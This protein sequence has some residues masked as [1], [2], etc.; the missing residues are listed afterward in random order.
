MKKFLPALLLAAM[1]AVASAQEA[2][3]S[4]TQSLERIRHSNAPVLDD[5]DEYKLHQE[6][7]KGRTIDGKFLALSAGL[8]AFTIADYEF[9]R[10]V[11]GN[12]CGNCRELGLI[13]RMY[14]KT[15]RGTYY[16][17]AG[18]A[19]AGVIG[20]SYALKRKGIEGWDTPLNIG[21]SVHM[22]T[23][24]ASMTLSF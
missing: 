12:G 15:G 6:K 22:G 4:I 16:A 7:P 13:T 9:A 17:I 24:T 21:I 11:Y 14:V 10:S 18:T 1:P 20:S 3:G 5:F 19:A 23:F 2:P 8:V